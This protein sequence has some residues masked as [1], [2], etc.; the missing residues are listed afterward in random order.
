MPRPDP[1]A[2][3]TRGWLLVSAAL[4]F[5]DAISLGLELRLLAAIQSGELRID[6]GLRETLEE[7]ADRGEAIGWARLALFVPTAVVYLV[8]LARAVRP[9]AEA[10]RTTPTRAVVEHFVPLVQLALPYRTFGRLLAA[11]EGSSGADC[12]LGAGREAERPAARERHRQA[13]EPSS[14]TRFVWWTAW[15]ATWLFAQLARNADVAAVDVSGFVRAT[16]L[17]LASAACAL[18]STIALERLV[19]RVARRANP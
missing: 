5:V 2:L 11:V 4:A 18:V 13:T 7:A 3:A 1:I 15:L 6:A 17:S 10:M 19:R 14:W 8:W 12:R 9:H 16:T